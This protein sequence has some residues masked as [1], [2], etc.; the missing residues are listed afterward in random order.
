VELD[1]TVAASS[2]S[3]LSRSSINSQSNHGPPGSVAK[4]RVPLSELSFFPP[5]ASPLIYPRSTPN[6]SLWPNSNG[7]GSKGTSTVF[8]VS[9]NGTERLD[10]MSTD[11]L[12]LSNSRVSFSDEGVGT[13]RSVQS[14]VEVE[15][16]VAKDTWRRSRIHAWRHSAS[17]ETSKVS[18]LKGKGRAPTAG[19]G[20]ITNRQP[21]ETPQMVIPR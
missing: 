5:S 2:S 7:S 9:G 12:T 14:D 16:D 11:S 6:D 13:P 4:R 18:M 1:E 15:L 19:G 3:Q 10:R 17:P 8:G 21:T 20:G